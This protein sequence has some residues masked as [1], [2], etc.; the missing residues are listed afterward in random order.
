MKTTKDFLHNPL[1]VI[2][3]MTQ[4]HL[5]LLKIDDLIKHKQSIKGN[6]MCMFEFIGSASCI[7]L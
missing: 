4:M 6:Q 2:K 3:V 5:H 1:N 7:K